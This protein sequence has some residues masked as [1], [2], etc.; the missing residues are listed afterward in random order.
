MMVSGQEKHERLVYKW[1]DSPVGRLKL[2]A[3]DRGLA[4][5]LW[6]TIPRAACG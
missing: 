6:A 3:T 1:V 2:V 5:I 4:G